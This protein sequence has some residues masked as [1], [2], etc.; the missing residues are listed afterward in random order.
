MKTL[1][2]A[3]VPRLVARTLTMAGNPVLFV[4]RS[5]LVEDAEGIYGPVQEF[6]R[7]NAH[8]VQFGPKVIRDEDM[9]GQVSEM[10]I[11]RLQ[12]AA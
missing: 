6:L 12:G 1:N 5:V 7:E 2:I 3:E 10:T 11:Y 8:V 9:A 4:N